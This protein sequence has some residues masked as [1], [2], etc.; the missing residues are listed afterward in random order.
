M[1]NA[2]IEASKL[3]AALTEFESAAAK[4]RDKISEAIQRVEIKN[5]KASKPKSAQEI[6]EEICQGILAHTNM[7]NAIKVDFSR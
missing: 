6:E 5:R 1:T 2:K 3:F 4:Y 7:L